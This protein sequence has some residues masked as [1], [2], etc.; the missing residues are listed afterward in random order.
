L[1]V[2]CLR[3]LLPGGKGMSRFLGANRR[4]QSKRRNQGKKPLALIVSA[5]AGATLFAAAD[6]AAALT[7][8]ELQ[9]E[10]AKRPDVTWSAGPTEAAAL[11]GGALASAERSASGASPFGLA[12]GAH[13]PRA[14]VTEAD[15]A[16]EADLP[17]QLDWRRVGGKDF[18]S[19]VRNQARCGSCVAFAALGALETQLNIAAGKAS[20]DLDLSEQDLFARI[21][22]CDRGSMPFLALS[23][24]KSTGVPDESCFPY[25]SGRLGKDQSSS[26]SCKDRAN[27]VIKITGSRSVS[28]SEAKKALQNGPLMTTMTVY[29][30]FMLYT[31]GVY[32]YVTGKALGGHAVT[33]VG[34]DDAAGAWIVRNSWGEGW[35]EGGYFRIKYTDKS[36][37]GSSNHALTVSSP[38]YPVKLASPVAGQALQGEALMTLLDMST[39]ET[40]QGLDLVDWKLTN[41]KTAQSVGG[42]TDPAR[43]PAVALDTVAMADGTYTVAVQGRSATG[44]LSSSWYA[45]VYVANELQALTVTLA[46]EF[47]NTAP[48]KDRV[49]FDLK[50]V[51]DG[52]PPTAATVF[53]AKQDGSHAGSIEVE[54]PGDWSKVGWRTATVP[55]GVYDV[56]AVARIGSLQ[57]FPS[58]RLV[59]TVGN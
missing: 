41:T 50:S 34:Y 46:P 53:F 20:L 30:D 21:G 28:A 36:G 5:M 42:T 48:V 7:L 37:V 32:Q 55:N 18:T 24:M 19:P 23:T 54:D 27:R 3:L 12:A 26:L 13:D 49:Y 1:F 33:I 8:Q 39:Q 44:A 9:T 15:L 43:D 2:F 25:A 56:W 29:E 11:Y 17:A 38:D 58:N 51:F 47:D 45:T 57:E 4:N 35:G 16:A 52:V 6:R 59:V 14:V 10:M 31:G 40:T 22:G